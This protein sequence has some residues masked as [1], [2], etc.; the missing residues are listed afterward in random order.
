LVASAGNSG[1]PPGKGDNISYPAAYDSVI[2]VAAIDQSDKRASWSSTGSELELA[3]P[4][5][6]IYSTYK[7]GGYDTLSGTSMA[8]PHVA[9]T[10][11]LVWAKNPTWS[12]DAVRTQLQNTADDLGATGWDS[13]YG[14]GLVDADEA[15]GVLPPPPNEPPTV[16]ITSPSDGSTFGSGDTI[17]FEG[18]ASDPEDGDLAASL[19]WTSNIE[20]GQI[21]TGSSFST[22]LSDGTHTITAKVT[23]SGGKTGSASIDITVGTIITNNMHVSDIYM[24]LK[25]SGPW[26][27][28]IAKISIVDENGTPVEGATVSGKW[29]DTTSDIDSGTTKANGQV[30]LR[31]DKVKNPKSGTTF[32]FSVDDVA[33]AG[34][35]YNSTANVETSDSITVP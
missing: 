28:A 9:G 5:V 16:Y 33:K 20:D 29:S 23:D 8:S 24:S 34:W 11:A 31:S 35:E 26:V 15:A 27:N 19:V 30:S 2:A 6:D 22:T 4:G 3:A 13:K 12:N 18:T 7:G 1:N 17:L 21:G 14:H 32:T 25:I 10:A